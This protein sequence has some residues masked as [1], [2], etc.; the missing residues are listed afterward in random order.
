MIKNEISAE[1][2]RSIV[3]ALRKSSDRADI[4][5]LVAMRTYT[6]AG[7]LKAGDIVINSLTRKPEVVES[8]ERCSRL[9]CY[10][11]RLNTRDHGR[12]FTLEIDRRIDV[13]NL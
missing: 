13:Y 8:V 11:V 9:G 1:S 5:T 6:K 12:E 4:N 7:D 2:K 3:E 10:L